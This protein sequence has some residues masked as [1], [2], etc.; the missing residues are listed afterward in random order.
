MTSTWRTVCLGLPLLAA[1]TACGKDAG[2]GATAFSDAETA[3]ARRVFETVCFTCHGMTGAGDGPGSA[4]LQPK[5][6]NLRDPAW[7]ASVTDAHVR[8]VITMGGAAVGKSPMMPAQPQLK[9]D[10]RVLDALVAHVRNLARD[11]H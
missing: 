6:R 11:I 5:P 2:G 9:N 10:P 1:L 4:A 7:Q 8:N 3:A